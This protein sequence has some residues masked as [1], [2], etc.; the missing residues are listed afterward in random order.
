MVHLLLN[1]QWTP[2]VN[3]HWCSWHQSLTEYGKS[4]VSVYGYLVSATLEVPWLGQKI[5]GGWT[6]GPGMTHMRCCQNKWVWS[7]CGQ[8]PYWGLEDEYIREQRVWETDILEFE[9][10]SWLHSLLATSLW[11]RYLTFWVYDSL[12]VNSYNCGT[13]LYIYLSLSNLVGIKVRSCER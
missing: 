13:Q 9:L 10:A 7:I 11:L 8:S 4:P 3:I 6:L 12:Y 2:S 5:S 1:L